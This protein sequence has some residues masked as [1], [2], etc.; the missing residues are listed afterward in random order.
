MNEPIAVQGWSQVS[1]GRMNASA[2]EASSEHSLP[3]LTLASWPGQATERDT[4]VLTVTTGKQITSGPSGS[5][6][7]PPMLGS[8]SSSAALPSI[9]LADSTDHRMVD[10]D[11]LP[12]WSKSM[13]TSPRLAPVEAGASGSN[14][15]GSPA[16]F[17]AVSHTNGTGATRN[18][19]IGLS[20]VLSPTHLS[21]AGL[22]M[23]QSADTL[24]RAAFGGNGASSFASSFSKFQE[25]SPEFA[26]IRKSPIS[27][28]QTL[29]TEVSAPLSFA[30][31]A[32]LSAASP[33]ASPS[34]SRA[35]SSVTGTQTG[36]SR[37]RAASSKQHALGT[38]DF[39]GA[40]P[41]GL[42]KR[43][44]SGDAA[45]SSDEPRI[46]VRAVEGIELGSRADD[47]PHVGFRQA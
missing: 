17:A 19:G 42:Q 23:V 13:S 28:R 34:M 18:V 25:K 37:H 10:E 7:A 45:M 35:S 6:E 27:R 5:Q 39:A 36:A 41:D 3:V 30:N 44:T 33:S 4:L 14:A 47:N 8:T 46:Q 26:A 12:A 16:A 22:D 9:F 1:I 11:Y 21:D 32:S 20:P 2:V 24:S 29:A 38:A 43:T 15:A 40:L 31:V